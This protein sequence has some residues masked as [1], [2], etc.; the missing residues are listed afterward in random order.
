VTGLGLVEGGNAS[1]ALHRSASGRPVQVAA[2]TALLA[3]PAWLL[4]RHAM[5]WSVVGDALAML[6]GIASAAG[7]QAVAYIQPGHRMWHQMGCRADPWMAADPAKWGRRADCISPVRG[8][9]YYSAAGSRQIR[10]SIWFPRFS[11]AM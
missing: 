6:P 9:V 7:V 1:S 10:A 11:K 2:H 5:L 4:W 3:V 8:V